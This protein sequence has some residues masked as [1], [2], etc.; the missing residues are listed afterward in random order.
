MDSCR[1]EKAYRHWG[2]DIGDEDTPLEAG[3]MFAV[4]LA[5]GTDFI[6]R[7]ALLCQRDK[8]CEKRLV[9]FMLEDPT[10]FL[11]HDEPIWRDGRMVGRTT[12]GA[13]GHHL[14]SAVALGYVHHGSEP[15]S[16]FVSQ[17]RFEIEV[18]G[19]RFKARAS[20]TPF[21]DPKNERMRA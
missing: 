18:A 4:K 17:G 16:A 14:G 12:S 21:Y 2:H 10:P 3:L 5:K 19:V 8:G 7:E 1:I 6:G 15:V 11:Y 9:Q 13:Y 20:L